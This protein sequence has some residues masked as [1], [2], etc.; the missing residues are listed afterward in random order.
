M[1]ILT[2]RFKNINSLRGEWKID[3][4]DSRFENNGLFVITGAT[5]AGKTTILDAICVALYHQTPRINLSP[6]QNQLMTRHTAEC[7]A[8][9]EFEVKG[10]G[11]RAFWS[12]RRARNK[13]D[14]RLQAPQ[15]ELSTLDGKIIAEKIRD[16]DQ[17][18]SQITGL[19]F[20]RFTKSI[21]LAQGG[22]A[23]FLNA[24]SNERAELL[25]ELTGT[26]IY[27]QISM[28][29]YAHFRE[30]KVEL[31][32]LTAR[33]E[34]A[35]LLEKEELE[36]LSTQLFALRVT[37]KQQQTMRDRVAGQFQWQQQLLQIEKEKQQLANA[38]T[39]ANEALLDQQ[40][41]LAYLTLNIPAEKLHP[42]FDR[43]MEAQ[44][45]WKN[46]SQQLEQH[47]QTLVSIDKQKKVCE[48]EQKKAQESHHQAQ[49]QQQ[50]QERAIADILNPLDKDIADLSQQ[51]VQIKQQ[52]QQGEKDQKAAQSES[53][54]LEKE[55]AALEQQILQAANYLDKYSN[56]QNLGEQLPLWAERLIQRSGYYSNLALIN[57]K[58]C[59]AEDK[60]LQQTDS[61]QLAKDTLKQ[62]IVVA[63]Q[64]AAD[65]N[66][67][68][69]SFKQQ[70]GKVNA[71]ELAQQLEQFQTKKTQQLRLE[72][73]FE[74]NL[75]FTQQQQTQQ[76]LIESK[77]I[78]Q[79][80]ENKC[81]ATLRLEYKNTHQQVKDLEKLL[82]QEQH[83][84]ELS[85]YRDRL[86]QDEA[87][88]L[89]GSHQHPA[90]SEYQ[91]LEVSVTKLRLNTK[92]QHVEQLS[93]QGKLQGAMLA[94]IEA[95]LKNANKMCAD[96]TQK[97]Q[98][99]AQDWQGLTAGLEL[100]LELTNQKALTDYLQQA[101]VA[102]QQLKIQL[103]DYSQAEKSLQSLDKNRR[104][105]QQAY[106]N[107]MH[108]LAIQ[109]KE[110]QSAQQLFSSLEKETGRL[111][112]DLS[113][114]EQEFGEQLTAFDF[115][116]PEHQQEEK[117]L[118]Q[119]KKG[120][121][122]YQKQSQLLSK[123]TELSQKIGS[124][125]H[126]N[127]QTRDSL[128]QQ[129]K[130]Q[131]QQLLGVEKDHQQK[132]AQ[133][134]QEFG[135][136]SA[137]IIR[138][139]VLQST[140]LANHQ[141]KQQQVLLAAQQKKSQK[142]T[143]ITETLSSQQQQQKKQADKS[144]Q[145]WQKQLEKS[146]FDHQDNFTAALLDKDKKQQL[147]ALKKALEQAQQHAKS[148][149]EYTTEQLEKHLT[150]QPNGLEISDDVALLEESVVVLQQEILDFDTALKELN[151][152]QGGIQQ[153][154]ESNEKR[155]KSQQKLLDEIDKYRQQYNDWAYL[156][157]LIGSADGAKFRKF[158]QGLTLDHLVHLSNEQL[159]RLH[160]RYQLARKKGDALELQVIDTWQADSQRDT[161]TLSGGES[162]LVSLA[163]ALA[164]SDLVS[165][166]TSIDS[167]FLDE[168][169]G[170]L[171]TETMEI[172]LD[173]LDNLNAS[174]KMI[175]VISHIEALK[176]RIPVQIEVKKIAGLGVSEL[177]CIG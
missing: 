151:T 35:D 135:E 170:T 158:A 79:V 7:L 156:N 161:T 72:T 19:N 31:G 154:L 32:R 155:R 29:V 120:W 104:E 84:A 130:D 141:L 21:L 140:E 102:E 66:Q 133:R 105:S 33:S 65:F 137:E 114:L 172:A 77:K 167:L 63:E 162:F 150:Q 36:Q 98:Q 107:Q 48:T 163:L 27:G 85:D 134:Q 119:W 152:Q 94:A 90:I 82:E 57:K 12:Q 49:L 64:A 18:I 147:E 14:G 95:D 75:E 52:K 70:F 16:K 112:A 108:A 177:V 126:N 40:D 111:Q 20:A 69:D 15:V 149:F 160:G 159:S 30:S 24:K 131:Q 45:L 127:Q 164:L 55:S 6:S 74:K 171:D 116:L 97:K 11:Y 39:T 139:A 173:A 145:Q 23:A 103:K 100:S 46:T 86:Q 138:D 121:E 157:G 124:Q 34:G 54:C 68:E 43:Q 148:K 176:E 80:A 53:N 115:S 60:V 136:Q 91:Q 89:C 59:V 47:Q 96:I 142:L 10:K 50:E 175:G 110:Q 88:P 44:Q 4:T 109:E 117:A 25:E 56:Y 61:I 92:K 83:I 143:G 58:M 153:A 17:Q 41:A 118:S 38:L 13:P 106:S 99:C 174:G 113:K 128:N 81:L 5:G 22:F 73:C 122:D 26:E 37:S 125:Q 168:G 8:E 165:H 93:E 146:P 132:T 51:L 101:Q 169:F 1:K 3:F 123:A 76:R 42:Y 9:V 87:C 78:E 71:E 62:T 129:L 28:Q 2:L 67:A 144:T 166:K